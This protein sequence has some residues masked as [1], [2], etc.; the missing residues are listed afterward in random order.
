MKVKIELY[1]TSQGIV[2]ENAENTYTK[3]P[4]FCVYVRETGTVTKIP[5]EKIFRITEDYKASSAT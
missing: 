3:G 5:V 1:E 4:L 2:I